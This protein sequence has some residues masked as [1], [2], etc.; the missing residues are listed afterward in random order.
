MGRKIR[1]LWMY[2]WAD[3]EAAGGGFSGAGLCVV[4]CSR[5]SYDCRHLGA[6]F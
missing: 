1:R 3:Y 2:S 4:I 6:A 5:R